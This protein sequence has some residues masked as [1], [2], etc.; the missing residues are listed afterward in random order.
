MVYR[1]LVRVYERQGRKRDVNMKY[2]DEKQHRKAE[3]E[4]AT[5][6][7][8]YFKLLNDVQNPTLMRMMS[9]IHTA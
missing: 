5:A 1:N 6:V 4:F 7:V 2:S 9:L 3:E 8:D